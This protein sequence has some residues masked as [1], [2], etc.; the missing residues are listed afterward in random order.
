MPH[1][2]GSARAADE[3]AATTDGRLGELFLPPSTVLAWFSESFWSHF[4]IFWEAGGICENVCFTIVKHYLLK[5]L[6][7][8][9]HDFFLLLFRYGFEIQF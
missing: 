5:V 1:G 2:V 3:R 6:G 8:P 9:V 4:G 7:I